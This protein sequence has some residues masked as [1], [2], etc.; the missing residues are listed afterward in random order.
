MRRLYLILLLSRS[1]SRPAASPVQM[2]LNPL[3]PGFIP[4]RPVR[5]PISAPL[6]SLIFP[7]Y[8]LLLIWLPPSTQTYDE[9]QA[10]N[11]KHSAIEN[12]LDM[13]ANSISGFIGSIASSSSS[14]NSA[15]T[16]GSN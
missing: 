5:T 2:T 13:L 6:I 7:H 3:S 10:I 4:S 1:S 11:A 9:I 14:S 16:A 12:K 8:L 15:Y